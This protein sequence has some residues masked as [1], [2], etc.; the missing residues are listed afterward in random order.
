V[1]VESVLIAQQIAAVTWHVV[2]I[3][4]WNRIAVASHFPVAP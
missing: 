3:N 4:G 2:E 1:D